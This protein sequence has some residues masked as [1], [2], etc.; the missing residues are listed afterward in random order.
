MCGAYLHIESLGTFLPVMGLAMLV[1]WWGTRTQK[2]PWHHLALLLALVGI[3]LFFV[4]RVWSGNWA[5]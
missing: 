5:G 4:L 1:F 3:Q 2:Q